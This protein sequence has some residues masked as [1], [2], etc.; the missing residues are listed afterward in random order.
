MV[1]FAVGWGT[2]NLF[3]CFG[4]E[5][6]WTETDIREMADALVSTGLAKCGYNYVRLHANFK[7]SCKLCPNWTL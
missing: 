1:E 3:G 4:V 6:N 7:I 2:W 5:H